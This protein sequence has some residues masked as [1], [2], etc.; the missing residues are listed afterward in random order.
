MN[1]K[2]NES[3]NAWEK[4]AEFWDSYMGDNS[5]DFHR[6]LVRPA[7]NDLLNPQS[8]DFVL[9][10]ACGN[11]NYSA[12]LAER[13]I[14]VVAFDYS[15][16][17]I[18]LAKTRWARF[19]KK[20]EFTV[21]DATNEESLIV[22]RKKKPFNKAVSN[23]AIMDISDVS[24]LFKCVGEMLCKN[25]IFVFA[26]QH[27][28]FVTLTDKYITEHSYMGEAIHGQPVEQCYYH[29]S[30]QDIFNLCFDNGFV[31]DGLQEKGFGGKEKPDILVVR[32]KRC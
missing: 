27:P 13:G 21:A 22:L 26:T 1:H 24:I 6:D 23:M 32:V 14:D 11:G 31:I 2:L 10:I 17:M 30:L 8:G 7:V 28:C 18:E 5:N 4:N 15:Q 3:L 12:Y 19:N 25:G 29:R 9:D 16:K 20:I